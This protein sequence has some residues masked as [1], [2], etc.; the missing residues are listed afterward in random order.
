VT[1]V[2]GDEFLDLFRQMKHGAFRLELRDRYNVPA[3]RERWEAFQARDWP[4]LD[5]LNRVQRATWMDLM[6]QVTSSGRHVERVRI[7]SEPPTNYIRFELRLNAG[8]AKA[9]EDIRY[10]PRDQAA[11]LPL[12]EVDYWLFDETTA[13]VLHFADDDF[14]TGMERVDDP[15]IVA[16]LRV[17]RDAAWQVAVPYPV[18]VKKWADAEPSPGA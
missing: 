5:E 13:V 2:T 8:N 14:L 7:V 18:Y 17:S 6:R 11:D 3:E 9:G 12:P 1:Q 10:L 16:R 15:D 4:R